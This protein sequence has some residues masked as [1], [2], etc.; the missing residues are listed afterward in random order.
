MSKEDSNHLNSKM[1]GSLRCL[2][3]FISIIGARG[4]LIRIRSQLVEVHG[5]FTGAVTPDTV[6]L[7]FLFPLNNSVS[8]ARITIIVH[9]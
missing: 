4:I 7:N 6:S 5:S 2:F 3:A 9:L 8:S 1:H